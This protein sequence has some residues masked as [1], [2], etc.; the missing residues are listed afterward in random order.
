MKPIGISGPK[1]LWLHIFRE[2]QRQWQHGN[3]IIQFNFL[4]SAPINS[5]N[6][7]YTPGG[8]G[9]IVSHAFATSVLRAT[10]TWM[11][12]TNKAME[13]INVEFGANSQT[14]RKRAFLDH[15]QLLLT[16][17]NRTTNF[18]VVFSHTHKND[19]RKREQG[20]SYMT[21]VLHFQQQQNDNGGFRVFWAV[22]YDDGQI[23][24]D[25]RSRWPLEV[26]NGSWTSKTIMA[27]STWWGYCSPDG[28]HSRG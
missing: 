15:S 20:I 22:F 6:L 17:D 2:S 26:E 23:P 4:G 19:S 25:W 11:G 1:T 27:F 18:R 7:Y 14:F 21:M 13:I 12:N 16:S 3:N 10:D 8:I 24:E 9:S 28:R 5:P